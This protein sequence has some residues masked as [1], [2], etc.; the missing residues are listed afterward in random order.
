MSNDQNDHITVDALTFLLTK[1]LDGL[2]ERIGSPVF[3]EP[4]GIL[5][6]EADATTKVL[7]R[8]ASGSPVAVIVFSRMVSPHLVRRGVVIAEEIRELIG[9]CLGEAIIKPIQSGYAAGRSYVILP[10]CREFSSLKLVRTLQRLA[11]SRSLLNWLQKATVAAVTAHAPS[12]ETIQSF[13]DML[14]HLARRPFLDEDIKTAIKKSLKKLEAGQW[15]PRYTFDHNDFWLGNVMFSTRNSRGFRS[16]YPYVLIDWGGA[17]S[18]GYGI[19]DLVRLANALK[20]SAIKLRQ[21]IVAHSIAL[22]CDPV[23]TCGHLLAAFGRLHQHLEF[24]PEKRFIMTLRSCWMT[25]KRALPE[26]N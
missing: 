5:K 10:W 9:E 6:E 26:N 23:D 16:R 20:L 14:E 7:I 25:F 13:G 3:L 24:F 15:K 22:R 4:L 21:E 12:D 11:L 17:N 19:Y 1:E 8:T 2:K 18:H